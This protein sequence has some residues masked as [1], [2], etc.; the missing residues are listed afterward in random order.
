M[1]TKI[2]AC[3]VG[4]A[5]F[6][7]TT[8]A[9]TFTAIKGASDWSQK[10][11]FTVGGAPATRT[12]GADDTVLL[13]GGGTWAFTND[14][15]GAAAFNVMANVKEIRYSKD[16]QTF[17]EITVPKGG[18]ASLNCA[19][20]PQNDNACYRFCDIVKKGEGTLNLVSRSTFVN[21]SW[22]WISDAT[23]CVYNF[24]ANIRAQEGTLRL[25]PDC[26]ASSCYAGII[27]VSE[28]AKFYLPNRNVGGNF[29]CQCRGVK[30]AGTIAN[31]QP[32]NPV[33]DP[34]LAA[35]QSRELTNGQMVF[36]GTLVDEDPN[37]GMRVRWSGPQLVTGG[38]STNRGPALI[39]SNGYA[40]TKDAPD[41]YGVTM[42][43]QLGMSGQASSLGAGSEI[44]FQWLGGE[45]WYG[46]NGETTDKKFVFSV[47]G[48]DKKMPII[49]NAGD[50]GG[51]IFNGANYSKTL[52]CAGDT[53]GSGYAHDVRVILSGN[54]TKPMRI[55]CPVLCGTYFVNSKASQYLTPYFLKRG[56]GAWSFENDTSTMFGSFEIDEGAIRFTS[57]DETGYASA[58]GKATA[59]YNFLDGTP[60]RAEMDASKVSPFA[61]TLAATNAA[62]RGALEYIG[63]K[64][65]GSGDRKIG[66][67]GFGGKIANNG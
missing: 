59:L 5:L 35:V 12:P 37:G 43:D 22:Q 3:T 56:S 66:L 63:E 27:D 34:M 45:L 48:E 60:T 7:W 65:T 52:W 28:G 20:F 19:I 62:T 6:G 26:V 15:A 47:P 8:F 2:I 67:A 32:T 61:V 38:K 50:V 46:G 14:T 16:T 40:W 39:W 53:S 10:E 1:N 9:E 58:L 21:G 42:T 36:N 25:L 29:T 44:N 13:I 55:L 33:L 57:I 18:E 11:S 51:V 4:F 31:D 41:G 64:A 49:F 54:N 23:K 24:Y 17:L 30:G